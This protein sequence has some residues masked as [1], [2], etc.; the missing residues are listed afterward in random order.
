MCENA[1]YCLQWPNKKFS[2]VRIKPTEYTSSVSLYASG[3]K[4]SK[5]IH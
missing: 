5:D 1:K 3:H 2:A 4:D